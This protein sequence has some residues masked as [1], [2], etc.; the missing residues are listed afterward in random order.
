M[1]TWLASRGMSTW[2]DISSFSMVVGRRSHHASL[3]KTK[4][5]LKKE[6]IKSPNDAWKGYLKTWA[7]WNSQSFQ[8]HCP[9]NLQG[10]GGGFTVLHMNPQL[11]ESNVLM[12]VV[13]WPMAIKLNPSWKTEVSKGAWIK[14]W[15]YQ[16][17]MLKIN[18]KCCVHWAEP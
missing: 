12:H 16:N 4:G 7:R 18:N 17:T 1:F 3:R 13:S 2:Q 5:G 10:G 11:Q 6:T 15:K 8:G 14:P 9:W